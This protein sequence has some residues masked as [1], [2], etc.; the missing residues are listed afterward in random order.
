MGEHAYL[1]DL[2]RTSKVMDILDRYNVE[3]SELL[4]L[5]AARGRFRLR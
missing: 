4:P 3:K 2:G 1:E 5:V